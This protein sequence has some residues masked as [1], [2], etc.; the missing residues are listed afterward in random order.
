MLLK[1]QRWQPRRLVWQFRPQILLDWKMTSSAEFPMLALALFLAFVTELDTGKV[2]FRTFVT[3]DPSLKGT[4][5]LE[6]VDME[7]RSNRAA[8]AIHCFGDA[9]RRAI[10]SR[11]TEQG[12]VKYQICSCQIHP[13]QSALPVETASRLLLPSFP[14][15]TKG[16]KSE[17][18][19]QGKSEGFDSYDQP[20]DLN[21]N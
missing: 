10:T 17:S 5:S 1:I 18:E 9:D 6:C 2:S 11:F 4:M 8:A 20:S 15:F 7:R 16:K 12:G 13:E 14:T 3:L 21:S 19:K